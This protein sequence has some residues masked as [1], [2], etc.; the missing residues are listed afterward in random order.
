M[1]VVL[2]VP[3]RNIKILETMDPDEIL[4]PSLECQTRGSRF[5]NVY[6]SLQFVFGDIERSAS[7]GES[8]VKIL[9]DHKE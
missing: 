6:S 7:K 5:F 8:V 1:C 2:K 4:T 3:R 9:E